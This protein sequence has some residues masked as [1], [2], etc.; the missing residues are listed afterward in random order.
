MPVTGYLVY[1]ESMSVT[2][3]ISRACGCS[4]RRVRY[5]RPSPAN[6]VGW[7]GR[8]GRGIDGTNRIYGHQK[9]HK[10]HLYHF[11]Y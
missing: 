10:G 8:N 6:Y 3:N 4:Y 9:I 5:L 2:S 7:T 11:P 1:R